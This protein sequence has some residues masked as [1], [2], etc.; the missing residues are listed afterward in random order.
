MNMSEEGKLMEGKKIIP[1]VLFIALILSFLPAIHD[2]QKSKSPL[3]EEPIWEKDYGHNESIRIYLASE[4]EFF[5]IREDELELLNQ[6]GE[7]KWSTTFPNPVKGLPT[8]KD[9]KVYLQTGSAEEDRFQLRCLDREEG[10]EKWNETINIFSFS[11]LVSEDH[12][13]FLPF[14]YGGNMTKISSEGEKIW[15]K[16]Y[17]EDSY[18]TYGRILDNGQIVV[19]LHRSEEDEIYSIS[20]EGEVNWNISFEDHVKSL[21]VDE[22]NNI[23]YIFTY[24]EIYKVNSEGEKDIVYEVKKE[25]HLKTFRVKNDRI[26]LIQGSDYGN[27]TSLKS[28]DEEGEELWNVSIENIDTEKELPSMSLSIPGNERIYCQYYNRSHDVKSVYRNVYKI[29]AFDLDGELEWEHNYENKTAHSPHMISKDG[30]IVTN[31]NE[32]EIYAYQGYDL[33]SDKIIPGFTSTLLLSSAVIVIF[34]HKIK[35]D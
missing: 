3:D 5:L 10:L 30:V 2:G 21:Q 32:G 16:S 4:N 35:Q 14:S 34:V 27:N 17:T 18:G 28:I 6:D 9:D 24:H 8:L 7:K 1:I 22:K 25:K 11:I 20:P 12:E 23:S 31:T 19:Y 13:I 15:T 26:Y 33:G 29:K